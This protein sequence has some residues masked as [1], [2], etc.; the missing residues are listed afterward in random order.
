[1]R[2][3]LTHRAAATPGSIAVVEAVGPELTYAD[4][5]ERV[6]ELAGRLAGNGVGVDDHLGVVMGTR[7]AFV[8][9][10]HAAMR[11]GA[12]L[13]PLNAQLTPGELGERIDRVDLSLLVCEAETEDVAQV[14]AGE[15]PVVS[16]DPGEE[17]PLLDGTAPATFDLPAWDY[18]KPLVIMFTSGTTGRPKAVQLTM[19]NLFASA[20]ASAF[21]LG[22]FP[23][24]RWHCCLPMYHMGGLAPIYRSTLYGTTVI[25]EEGF[26]A[27]ATLAAMAS[28][29]ATCVSLVPTMLRRLLNAADERAGVREAGTLPASLRFVLLGGAPAPVEL[30]ERCEAREIPVCPTYGTTETASQIATARS[31][32]AFDEP[33]S[34]GT[35]LLFTDVTVVD[36]AGAEQPPGE[37]GELVVSGPTVMPGYYDAPAETEAAIGSHGFHTGDVGYRDDRGRLYVLNRL[38]ERIVTGGENVDPGEV[39]DVLRAHSA[40]RDAAVVGLDD[41]EWGQRVGALIVPDGDLV[42]EALEV[43]C[44][45]RLAEFKRPRTVAFANELPRTP[46]GT[47]DRESVRKRLR[48]AGESSV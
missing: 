20:C 39:A 24:D 28:N 40:V 29:R 22:V 7:P 13:V 19:S 18:D 32:E 27:E 36:D 38:D 47:V 5:D 37:R 33:E 3:W 8:D 26:E 14:A 12:V 17:A 9:V 48:Q 23:M 46:S 34:V 31:A 21:R 25:V 45:E 2:D 11:L 41:E 16:V 44:R 15:V 6:E 42:R 43:H 30:I 1:M 35:P 4:L 10:V